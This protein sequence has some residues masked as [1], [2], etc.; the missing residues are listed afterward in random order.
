MCHKQQ[1]ES[2]TYSDNRFQVVYFQFKMIQATESKR[3]SWKRNM[4]FCVHRDKTTENTRNNKEGI[5]QFI[6]KIK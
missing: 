1:Q 6:Y 5:G 4:Y 2:G 3:D